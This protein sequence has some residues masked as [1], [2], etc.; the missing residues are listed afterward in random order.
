MRFAACPVCNFRVH[1]LMKAKDKL[2]KQNTQIVLVYESESQNLLEYVSGESY[3]FTFIADPENKLYDLYSVERSFGKLMLSLF[4]G[5]IHKAK[6][7]KGLFRKNIQLDGS[8]TR[9]GAEFLINRNRKII[10][11]HY[12]KFLGDNL[13]IKEILN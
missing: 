11:A 10:I 6:T 2:K 8:V 12:G 5:M 7:G 3:P 13:P 9:I 4:K 1:E